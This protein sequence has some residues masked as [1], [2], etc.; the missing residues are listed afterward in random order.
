MSS[1]VTWHGMVTALYACPLSDAQ[2]RAAEVGDLTR[3]VGRVYLT[4]PDDVLDRL[5]RGMAAALK[6][7]G[8][9]FDR[10]RYTLAQARADAIYALMQRPAETRRRWLHPVEFEPD[11][12]WPN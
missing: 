2:L 1:V 8:P 7:G 4:V 3:Y 5:E 9:T 6:Q 11:A 10:Q 12:L